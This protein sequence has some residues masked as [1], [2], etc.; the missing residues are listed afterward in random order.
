MRHRAAPTLET[1]ARLGFG[2]RGL[3]Y[4]L[5][6]GLAV[7][8]A[9]GSG[10][11]AGGSRSALQALLGQPFGRVL[12]GLIAAGLLAFAA[13]RVIGA[14][15]DADHRGAS[16]KGLAIRGAHL[17]GGA[18]YAGLAASAAGLAL[19]R[20]GGGGDDQAA[21]DWSAWLMAQPAGR[22]LLAA[23]GAAVI[24]TG[25]VYLAKAW[26]GAVTD[27]LALTP[28]AQS[29]AVPMGRVGYAARGIV[30]GIIGA[31]LIVAALHANS[32]EVKGLG[33][34]LQAL[35]AQPYGRALLAL[36]AAGLFAFG[37]FG[38]IQAVYRRIDA[39]NLDDAKAALEELGRTRPR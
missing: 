25:L 9:I 30:F 37:V 28:A 10:G 6:G 36:V 16:G 21:Q 4:G 19:G 27:R 15:T 18:I 39:P 7:L 14:L 33:G 3:V 8:A 34:A 38:L 23:V 24:A 32:G 20:A 22:W 29:W 13:W 11:R 2:A 5:V 31:F 12:L 17:L 26:R 35:Q 1:F